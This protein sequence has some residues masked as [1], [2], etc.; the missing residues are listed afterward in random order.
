MPVKLAPITAADIPAVAQ[1]MHENLNTAVPASDWSRALTVPWQVAPPNHGYF[2]AEDGHVVGAY[3]AYYSDRPVDGRVEK[4]CNLGAWCVLESH[5]HQ[6]LRLLTTLL[7][8]K[9]Y[10]FTDF[11]PSGSVVPLNRRLKFTDLDTTTA[12]IP[13]LPLPPGRGGV[14]VIGDPDVVR[15]TLSDDEMEVYLDH[16]DAAAAQH[17]VIT[18]PGDHCHVVFRKDARKHVR[19]FASILYVSNPEMFRRYSRRV[20]GRLLTHHGI[21]ATL[22]ELRVAGGRPAGSIVLSRSRPKMFRSDSLGP[23]QI[24]YLYSELTCLEW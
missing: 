18:S 13:N 4:F 15:A 21:A 9:G 11:S 5:R 20:A 1:F 7:K 12:L 6:G 2:L 3:L 24:D 22:V 14:R 19:A 8:Q 10:H 16:R 23:D 17:L